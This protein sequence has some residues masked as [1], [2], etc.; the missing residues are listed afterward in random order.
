M[1]RDHVINVLQLMGYPCHTCICQQKRR[2]TVVNFARTIIPNSRNL[3]TVREEMP[4]CFT[5]WNT[6]LLFLVRLT[7]YFESSDSWVLTLAEREWM[8]I[9]KIIIVFYSAFHW[10]P[11]SSF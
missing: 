5:V 4:A 2:Q 3:S 10:I 11:L 1:V 6:T 7:C 8:M 9:M